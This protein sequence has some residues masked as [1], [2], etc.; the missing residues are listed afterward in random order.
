VL[1]ALRNFSF[2]KSFNA[3][4]MYLSAQPVIILVL[5]YMFPFALYVLYGEYEE[6][7]AFKKVPNDSKHIYF[8]V[9]VFTRHLQ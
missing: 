7:T 2:A 8:C 4:I 1:M 6:L 5:S 9:S 3:D